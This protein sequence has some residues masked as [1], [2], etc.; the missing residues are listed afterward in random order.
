MASSRPNPLWTLLKLISV[1][2]VAGILTAGFFLPY[3]GGAGVAA[4]FGADKF[5]G[6][7]CDLVETPIEQKTN[8]LASDGSVIAQLFNQNRIVVSLTSVPVF[9]QQALIDTEDRRFYDHHGVD[10]Q[11]LARAA[12]K[13]SDGNT[14]GASTLTQQYVKQMRYYQAISADDAAAA[15]AAIDQ[16][17]DRKILEAQCALKIERENSKEQILEKYL[18]IAFFGENSYGIQTAAQTYF[19]VNIDQVTVAQAAMLVGLV[20]SPTAYDPFINPTAATNRRNLV[21]DNMVKEGNLSAVDGE[22]FKQQPIQ[23]AQRKDVARGCAYANGNIQNVGYFCDF[24]TNW[25]TTKGGLTS[26]ALD[27]GGLSIKTTLDP[28]LQNT[29]QSTVWDKQAPESV[30]TAVMPGIDPTNGAIKF[31]TTSKR[32]GDVAGDDSYTNVD[33]I[34]SPYAG[35][36]STYKYFTM[37]AALGVGATADYTL[38]TGNSY[39]PKNCPQKG[40]DLV[41]ITN[42]GSYASTLNLRNATVQSSNTYFVGVE[43][44]LFG[45]DVAPIV[46]MAQALGISSLNQADAQAAPKSIAQATIDEKRYTLTLGQSPTGALELAS[47]YGAV[48]ND[49]VYCPPNPIVSITNPAGQ[50]V[51]YTKPT[52]T[53]VLSQQVARSAVDILIGDT[54]TS[55]GTAA[56]RFG[57]YYGAGGSPVAGKTGTD[58]SADLQTGKDNGG[59]SALWFVGVTPHLVSSTALVNF[60]NPKLLIT[61]VPGFSGASANRAAFGAVSAGIWTASLT[62]YLVNSGGW[63][64]PS[65]DASDGMANVPLVIGKSAADAAT[66]LQAAGFNTFK[67]FTDCPGGA[68]GQVVTSTP[69]RAQPGATI[70]ICLGNGTAIP[71]TPAT[72]TPGATVPGATIPGAATP[73]TPAPGIT[74]TVPGRTVTVLPTR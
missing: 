31:Y 17:V 48:A 25:L 42:A 74:V 1:L 54:K 55:A 66:T 60:K 72:P 51:N 9:V 36:G 21:L 24:V 30:T 40:E 73:A 57:G 58:N 8:I 23:L 3:V 28:A 13:S 11:G 53:R 52:C 69:K 12:L 2:A 19:G 34:S 41:P 67:S 62:D 14:Q 68:K 47:A 6:T 32:Y 61:D 18:N 50:P 63:T 20:Q 59:N 71:T 16:N 7:K 5:L 44:Q 4:R 49:G 37:L 39:T 33:I 45:C 10:L 56:S 22:A 70:L 27:T 15:Q 38:T 26:N 43:D 29:V 46:S 65:A 64:W 35:T